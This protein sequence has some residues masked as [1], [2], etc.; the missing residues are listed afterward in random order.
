M[1]KKQGG[2]LEIGFPSF[3]SAPIKYQLKSG[4][5]QLIV[6]AAVADYSSQDSTS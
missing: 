2:K 1:E 3:T 5:D 6:S 4:W